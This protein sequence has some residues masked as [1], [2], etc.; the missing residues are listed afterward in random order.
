L[1]RELAEFF[2]AEYRR[3]V[4]LLSLYCRD[5]HVAEELAQE[6]FVRV[7]SN[8]GAVRNL[9]APAA[10]TY[11]VAIN[12][13]NS[14]LRRRLA[15]RRASRRLSARTVANQHH[16]DTPTAI[17]VRTAVSRLPKRKRAVIV[18]RFF[19]DLSVREVSELLGIPEGTVKT[20]TASGLA[21]LRANVND[22]QEIADAS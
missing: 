19:A 10:W 1:D 3:V 13:A 14:Y 7:I 2:R 4:G 12:L 15:E 16:P 18:L 11:R 21:T 17:A 6:T 22:Y 5:R 20:L 9:D 8:W